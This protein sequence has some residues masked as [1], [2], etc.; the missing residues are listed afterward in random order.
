MSKIKVVI[1]AVVKYK[2]N[3]VTVEITDHNGKEYKT[4]KFGKIKHFED[5]KSLAYI[6]L[7]S[8]VACGYKSKTNNTLENCPLNNV[9]LSQMN[10]F[11]GNCLL[12]DNGTIE[13]MDNVFTEISQVTYISASFNKEGGTYISMGREQKTSGSLKM[14]S[15]SVDV[16]IK[17]SFDYNTINFTY[18][19]KNIVAI[20]NLED[21]TEYNSILPLDKQIE[22]LEYLSNLALLENG[23]ID[24]PKPEKKGKIIVV[25]GIDGVGKT[26]IVEGLLNSL[27]KL[28]IGE[29]VSI[30]TLTTDNLTGKAL[31]E[32]ISVKQEEIVDGDRLIYNYISET[33][34]HFKR[35]G[36]VEDLISRGINV[37]LDRSYLSTLAYC[38]NDYMREIVLDTIDLKLPSLDM[39]VYVTANDDVI[40]K[41]IQ[42][43][44]IKKEYYED[45]SK[46][47]KQSNVFRHFICNGWKKI[48]NHIEISNNGEDDIE[49]VISETTNLIKE[50]L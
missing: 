48:N 37:I 39:V 5:V 8:S 6:H 32:M 44:G 45:A 26:T 10:D 46:R 34:Y 38:E 16:P 49:K 43:R 36:G 9:E 12:L 11:V 47:E 3:E 7:I 23:T 21:G 22:V 41:R 4:K 24:I 18:L 20:Y 40:D 19:N 25:E 15:G 13:I 17:F 33:I 27:N 2:D 31:R 42:D 30:K 28:N 1:K 50:K 14:Y 35:K 29:F